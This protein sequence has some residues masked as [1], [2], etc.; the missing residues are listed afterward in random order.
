MVD[1]PWERDVSKFVVSVC[2]LLI[3]VYIWAMLMGYMDPPKMVSGFS[4]SA[5]EPPIYYPA[6]NAA[7]ID[8]L[9]SAGHADIDKLGTAGYEDTLDNAVSQQ[10][11]NANIIRQTLGTDDKDVIAASNAAVVAKIASGRGLAEAQARLAAA[12]KA[13]KDI[14]LGLEKA[15]DQSLLAAAYDEEAARK[16]ALD[17][18]R[19]STVDTTQGLTVMKSDYK[20]NR[21]IVERFNGNRLM[22]MAY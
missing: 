6:G 7:A 22:Q 9:M 11:I 4:E 16:A 12:A 18:L 10:Q 19:A 3:V 17:R 15:V 5:Y 21:G 13:R 2:M 8:T 20:G 1:L 14:N